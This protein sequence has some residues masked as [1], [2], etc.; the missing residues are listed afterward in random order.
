MRLLG[1]ALILVSVVGLLEALNEFVVL[2]GA[3]LR[4]EDV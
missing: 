2:R 3:F 1:W 4:G